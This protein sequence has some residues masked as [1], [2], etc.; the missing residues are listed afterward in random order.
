MPREEARSRQKASKPIPKFS[1]K[2]KPADPAP[3][4]DKPAADHG[5]N[6]SGPLGEAGKTPKPA[7]TL[8]ASSQQL[9]A[10]SRHQEEGFVVDKRGDALIRQYGSNNAREVP[11][12]RRYGSGR[13]LGADGFIRFERTGT[14]SEF[15]F[16]GYRDKGP[17]LSS[18]RKSFRAMSRLVGGHS[19]RVR[20]TRSHDPSTGD[21]Y[22]ALRTSRSKGD[23]T[24]ASPRNVDDTPA[25]RSLHVQN[26][27]EVDDILSDDDH[28]N[29]A[30][31]SEMQDHEDDPITQRSI[32]LGRKV[33]DAPN[34]MNAWH[35]LVDH[36]DTLFRNTARDAQHPTFA[37][38]RSF[39]DIKLSLLEKA[40]GFAETSEQRELVQLKLMAEGMKVW[41]DKVAARRWE[42]VLK[43]CPSSQRLWQAQMVYRQ[44]DIATFRYEDTKKRYISRLEYLQRSILSAAPGQ[45]QNELCCQLVSTF[46][47]A[48]T[49][50]SD[51]G[52]MELACSVWQA[53]LELTFC[54][55]STGAPEDHIALFALFQ[56][57]WDSEVPRFGEA[58]SISWAKF[59][60]DPSQF[61]PPEPNQ[62]E[63]WSPPP[64]RDAYKAWAAKE[65]WRSRSSAIAART[66]DQGA[67]DDPF[68]VVLSSDV[69]DF[70]IWIPNIAVSNVKPM[71][72]NA[73]LA[74]CYLPP[75][76]EV[77][78]ADE[79]V[80]GWPSRSSAGSNLGLLAK[81][82]VDL[83]RSEEVSQRTPDFEQY[84]KSLARTPQAMLHRADWFMYF[85]VSQ[86]SEI[87][88]RQ[89]WALGALKQLVLQVAELQLAPYYF[90]LHGALAPGDGRKT[91]KALLKKDPV[92]IDLYI[93]YSAREHVA[94]NTESAR[95]IASAALGLPNLSEHDSVRLI[96]WLAWMSLESKELT[97]AAKNIMT[98]SDLMGQAHHLANRQI[99]SSVAD[100]LRQSM[101]SKRDF[102]VSAGNS[103]LASAYAES[104]MLLEYLT[105]KSNKEPASDHQGDIWSALNSV[106]VFSKEL[107]QRG[108][109]N[110]A[111]HEELLQSASRLLYFH[112][113]NG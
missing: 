81:S 35:E 79:L 54:R 92:N 101:R 30:S 71:L 22:L 80:P 102:S 17:I 109:A 24:G 4:P 1:F 60:E 61:E 112:A 9:P 34:D 32:E 8:S 47:H 97:E 77:R 78:N 7:P 31:D 72:I 85:E 83:N 100:E 45:L 94:G 29:E 44:A 66:L 65:H 76:L 98:L 27:S 48:T 62:L 57:F 90:A 106:D 89:L 86:T 50:L 12:Y 10:R 15:F 104:L 42:E 88:P 14:R 26:G 58:N 38:V 69:Q 11:D 103:R 95:N 99:A 64:T 25:Y 21:D 5:R 41:D 68:R 18:D 51:A 3:Q 16:R 111:E 2:A 91:A 87:H 96:N 63:A 28:Q 53:S 20:P 84:F 55:P 52:Y 105:A 59:A 75:A 49:F 40:L 46:I 93:G 56:E 110:T 13:V 39:A 67:E 19:T 73:F 108:V 113:T 37:E 74:F 107:Q 33:R 70:L 23:E 43:L 36:Q 6:Q 82:Q